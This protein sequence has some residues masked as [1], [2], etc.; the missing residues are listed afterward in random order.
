[1]T[2]QQIKSEAEKFA[3]KH[4]PQDCDLR[5]YTIGYIA[6]LT[7][8]GAQGERWVSVDSGNLP[9]SYMSVIVTDGR[10]VLIGWYNPVREKF[11]YASGALYEITHWMPLPSPPS[12]LSSQQTKIENI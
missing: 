10:G 11:R 4:C 1:M 2:Q 7:A 6:A 5:S 9:E 8:H 12:T 3:R